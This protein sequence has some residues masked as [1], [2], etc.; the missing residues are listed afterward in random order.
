MKSK[1]I[2]KRNCYDHEKITIIKKDNILHKS[3]LLIELA[4]LEWFS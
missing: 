1:Q 2:F 3:L 4:L